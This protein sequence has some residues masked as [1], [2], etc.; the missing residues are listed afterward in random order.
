T[1]ASFAQSITWQKIYNGPGN[2][3][4]VAYDICESSDG[5]FYAVGAGTPIPPSPGLWVLKLNPYNGDTLWTRIIPGPSVYA[6]VA[7]TDGGCVITGGGGGTPWTIK[8][9]SSG[10]I[11]WL[12]TYGGDLISCDD[13]IRTTDGNYVICGGDRSQFI[14]RGY[15]LKVDSGGNL[16]WQRTYPASDDRAFVAIE[17]APGGGY[18]LA[19]GIWDGDTVK[20]N[21]IKTD[22]AG[23]ITWERIFR[24]NTSLS[25]GLRAISKLGDNY[26][27][28]GQGNTAFFV[29]TDLNGDILFTKV[30]TEYYEYPGTYFLDMK[31]AAENRFIF[32]FAANYTL[33]EDSSGYVVVTDSLG[34]TLLYRFFVYERFPQFNAILP[35]NNGDII[36]AGLIQPQLSQW[37][38]V[39]IVRTDSLLNTPPIGIKRIGNNIPSSFKLYQNYPNPFNPVTTISFDIPPLTSEARSHGVRG[40]NVQLKIYDITGR[41]VF[42]IDEYK[43]AGSYSVTFDGTNLASGLYLYRIEVRQAGSTTGNFI[44]TKKMVLIK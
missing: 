15:L 23:N 6:V 25:S 42:G 2:M 30:F 3:N 14:T 32:S 27:M 38:D 41:E 21:L 33:A 13:I 34:N 19:G 31:L 35:L 17:E 18:I 12:K 7:S 26:I 36:F 24:T 11:V 44:E 4:D 5:Y 43:Q 28:G 40:M 29:R 16:I 20:A 10:N 9:S 39:Y 37:A 22:T 8:Y 1:F